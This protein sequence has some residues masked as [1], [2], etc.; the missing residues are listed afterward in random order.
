MGEVG[1]GLVLDLALLTARPT[2]QADSVLVLSVDLGDVTGER[3][4]KEPSIDWLLIGSGPAVTQRS[5]RSTIETVPGYSLAGRRARWLR[6]ETA[7]L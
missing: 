5:S 4:G 7:L 3:L 2:Q 6:R 1:E